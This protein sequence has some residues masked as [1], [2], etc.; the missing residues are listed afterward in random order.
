MTTKKSPEGRWDGLWPPPQAKV[1]GRWMEEQ[2]GRPFICSLRKMHEY[3]KENFKSLTHLR[4]SRDA[5][6]FLILCRST[7]LLHVVPLRVKQNIDSEV[8]TFLNE[9]NDRYNQWK[10]ELTNVLGLHYNL[11][12]FFQD[13]TWCWG[14]ALQP[15]RPVIRGLWPLSAADPA[16]PLDPRKVT[17][18]VTSV[19]EIAP[20]K[21][22]YSSVEFKTCCS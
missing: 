1:D 3:L 22:N 10:G 15:R 2:Q 19:N 9:I 14:P 4:S 17:R 16:W 6:W 8:T 7:C 21:L 18:M 11:Q 20:P 12:D 5:I 13:T